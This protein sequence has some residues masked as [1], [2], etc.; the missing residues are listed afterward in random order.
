MSLIRMTL[1]LLS[2]TCIFFIYDQEMIEHLFIKCYEV[3]IQNRLTN[4]GNSSY[5]NSYAMTFVTL[6]VAER[7]LDVKAASAV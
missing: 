2:L 6:Q 5:P 1:A 3:L 7:A 4:K